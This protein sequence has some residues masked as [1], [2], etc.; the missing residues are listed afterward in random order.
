MQEIN[1]KVAVRVRP[2]LNRERLNGEKR[3]VRVFPTTNQIVLGTDKGFTFDYVHSAHSTQKD[4]YQSVEP[5]VESIFEGYNATVFAYGQTGSG[6]THTIG[7]FN[8]SSVSEEQQGI[9]PRAV[10]QIYDIINSK[11][12]IHFAVRVSYIEIYLEELCD[13][14]DVD[15]KTLHVREDEKG[16]TVISGVQEVKCESMED[17]FSC[18]ESGS[19]VR[20]T[21]LTQMNE[22]SSRSHSVFTIVIDQKW[23]NSD[24]FSSRHFDYPTNCSVS[25]DRE[26]SHC[27]SAKFHFVD[28]A[29]SE[30]AHRIGNVGER[31]KESVHINTGLLALGNVISSLADSKKKAK[32]IPYRDSKITRI[33][34]DSLGGN[35]QTLMIC[36]VSPA[37][38]GFDETLN[39]LKYANRVK[40]IRNKPII[41][42]DIQSIRFE[43]MQ[44]EILNLRE[45]LARQQTRLFSAGDGDGNSTSDLD[46]ERFS[47]QSSNIKDME[48]KV[49]R[50]QAECHHYQQLSEEA[51]KQLLQIQERDILSKSQNLSLND[52]LELR[53]EIMKNVTSSVNITEYW[54]KQKIEELQADIKKCQEQLSSDEEIFIQMTK[55]NNSLKEKLKEMT[56]CLQ[57][58][59]HILALSE[60][61]VKQQQQQLLEQQIQ[62]DEMRNSLKSP[63]SCEDVQTIEKLHIR[64]QTVPIQYSSLTYLRPPSRQIHT[65]P[66]LFSL[67]RIMQ[68]FRARSQLLV[69]NL[70]DADEV[71]Q[72]S[73]EDIGQGEDMSLDKIQ[74]ETFKKNHSEIKRRSTFKVG[75]L[76]SDQQDTFKDISCDQDAIT[77]EVSIQH[78]EMS[79]TRSRQ[80]LS[81]SSSIEEEPQNEMTEAD[82]KML[83]SN[84]KL[85]NLASNIRMKEQ[86]IRELVK[87]GK[88]ATS[89]NRQYVQKIKEQEK[90]M[91]K[92]QKDLSE[93]RRNLQDLEGRGD[94]TDEKKM[95][96][97]KIEDA[98]QKISTLRKQQKETVKVANITSQNEK[99]IEDL[100]LSVL[101]MKQ[102]HETLQRKLK[103]EHDKK[104]KIERVMQ[105][106]KVRVKQLEQRNLQQQKILKRK[107]EEIAQA[108]RK[109]RGASLP[110]INSGNHD[111]MEEKK[112]QL[113]LEV[114]KILDQRQQL[115]ELQKELQRKEDII[116]NREAMLVE[117]SE[118]EIKKLRSSQIMN[119]DL[120]G[121][122]AKLVSV[123][124][125]IET[126]K[127]EMIK[128][129]QDQEENVQKE[130]DKLKQVR[131]NL[132]EQLATLDEK[133]TD[134]CLL[135]NQEERRL[136]E[137]EEAVEELDAA[138]EYKNKTIES[139]QMELRQSWFSVQREGGILSLFNTL[140]PQEMMLLLMKYFEKV[141]NFRDNER[142]LSHKM[143]EFQSRIEEQDKL[144]HEAEN[145]HQRASFDIDRRLTQQQQRYEQKIGV[146]MHQLAQINENSED[147]NKEE[148]HAKLRSLE[149]ELYYYKKTSRDLKK[150]LR[151]KESTSLCQSEDLGPK[152]VKSKEFPR[153][154]SSTTNRNS[155]VSFSPSSQ[156]NQELPSQQPELFC[157]NNK[158]D[159]SGTKPVVAT[160][161]QFLDSLE[162]NSS[163]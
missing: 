93:T 59:E 62:L 122:S 41:N 63:P 109:L 146:L 149:K 142:K 36:C 54:N 73:F 81:S 156:H 118:L 143:N 33:L 79:I 98:E 82:A 11:G 32:H 8:L 114:E 145:H 1:V 80:Q 19:A 42:R 20:H 152:L 17:V 64:P 12:N 48:E 125:T 25:S 132:K 78:L 140:N 68:N 160:S 99:K 84:Q 155:V 134:G 139:R 28:L 126:K 5:L 18:L 119:K 136:I 70:E 133:L 45:E 103:E 97:K 6:K 120:M 21:G 31:F 89:L 105:R 102:Q 157:E 131:T 27:M 148:P 85:S 161:L 111:S 52:W 37:V 2:L 14:L 158:T 91:V 4:V 10:R 106:E 65:S 35:A 92:L 24:I 9:I 56:E 159:Q 3:C 107:N 108:Q 23:T 51:Y 47:T 29:G 144:L 77:C 83:E 16:N 26:I 38:S 72:L 128:A 151:D 96:L 137:L 141:I 34:K 69:V 94:E 110:R 60:E 61:K 50:L 90:E 74:S 123:E 127:L 121:L 57:E 13:L 147:T 58:K 129:S 43:E 55:E 7:G 117:K 150:K 86:F 30:R 76:R 104:S 100:K 115:E 130:I 116:S 163:G 113:D 154:K 22:H 162:V 135:S 46:K 124:K 75:K 112:R 95:Y 138:I 15:N 153:C 40:D 67:E 49:L 71:L 44:T 87:K 53:E 66:A 88:D 39:S 101:K